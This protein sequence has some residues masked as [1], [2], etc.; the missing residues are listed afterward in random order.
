MIF[1]AFSNNYS[2]PSTPASMLFL[3]T[4]IQ[5][6]SKE[7]NECNGRAVLMGFFFVLKYL[8]YQTSLRKLYFLFHSDYIQMHIQSKALVLQY[9][10][11][12]AYNF[13]SIS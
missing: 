11:S 1:K 5:S 7:L 2:D 3:D 8:Q 10:A 9:E 13:I 6:A 4:V 12:W